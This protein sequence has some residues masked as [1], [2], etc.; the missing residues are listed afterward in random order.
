MA[1]VVLYSC[2]TANTGSINLKEDTVQRKEV[3]DQILNNRELTS[4]FM[5]QMM[6]NAQTMNWMMEDEAFM[7]H[8]FNE[9]NMN[10]MMQHNGHFNSDSMFN[11][12]KRYHNDSSIMYDDDM[13]HS[14]NRIHE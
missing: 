10:Y 7:Q 13:M 4:E 14:Q 2:N 8:M 5:N 1:F 3:F 6:Q 11:M 9:D 12:M